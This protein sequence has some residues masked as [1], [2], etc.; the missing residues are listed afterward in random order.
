MIK[1]KYKFKYK[2][3]FFWITKIVIGHALERKSDNTFD[4]NRMVL[5]FEDGSIEVISNWKYCS[6]KLGIDWVLAQKTALEKEIN[7]PIKL[8]VGK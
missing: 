5:Y 8:N 4:D 3:N 2:R 1:M 7:Q 6:L